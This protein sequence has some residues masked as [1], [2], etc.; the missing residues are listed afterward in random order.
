M[1]WSEDGVFLHVSNNGDIYFCHK[2][3]IKVKDGVSEP[4]HLRCTKGLTAPTDLG[5]IPLYFL[6]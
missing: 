4:N 2:K 1:D 3:F 6:S 5:N